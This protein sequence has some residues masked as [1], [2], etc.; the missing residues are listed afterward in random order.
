MCVC[1][2]V[3]NLL[4]VNVTADR[5]IV[6]LGSTVNFVCHVVNA[7]DMSMDYSYSWTHDGTTLTDE[8][9]TTF[10]LSSFSMD[11]EGTYS[12]RAVNASGFFGMASINIRLGGEAAFYH[13]CM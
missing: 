8:T 11:D 9:S 10:S 12:C 1:F 4:E 2:I 5:T 7:P 6:H 13:V 3:R